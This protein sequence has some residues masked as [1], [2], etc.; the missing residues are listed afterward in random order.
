MVPAQEYPLYKV[1]RR[2]VCG[3]TGMAAGYAIGDV[4]YMA[5]MRPFLSCCRDWQT[6]HLNIVSPRI[7][8]RINEIRDYDPHP[9]LCRISWSLEARDFCFS[10]L[11][12][13]IFAA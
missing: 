2:G 3:L 6:S 4:G 1:R 5:C 8:L 13:D 9:H 11:P 10:L 12:A 7:R